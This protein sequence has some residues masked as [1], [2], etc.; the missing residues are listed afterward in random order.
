MSYC[1]NENDPILK[2]DCRSLAKSYKLLLSKSNLTFKESI[3][4]QTVVGDVSDIDTYTELLE[5]GTA[6][7]LEIE[8]TDL[9]APEFRTGTL[10]TK[11]VVVGV[12][13]PVYIVHVKSNDEY[14]RAIEQL[15]YYSGKYIGFIQEDDTI[16]LYKPDADSSD[17][18]MFRLDQVTPLGKS[19]MQNGTDVPTYLIRLDMR[20]KQTFGTVTRKLDFDADILEQKKTYT[21]G[22]SSG[23]DLVNDAIQ[24]PNGEVAIQDTTGDIFYPSTSVDLTGVAIEVNGSEVATI[25]D[26]TTVSESNVLTIAFVGASIGDTVRVVIDNTSPW[27]NDDYFGIDYT[28]T[29][30]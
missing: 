20:A 8:P 3:E 21:I 12:D 16:Q 25:D 7:M 15:K 10:G 4:G 17:I 14:L 29:V 19:P 27:Y 9:T 11:E 28:F 24:P 26:G 2:D 22:D 5:A 13:D 18:K 30:V 6:Q 23:F 1:N